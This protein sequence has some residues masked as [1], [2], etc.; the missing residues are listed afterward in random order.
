M[1]E[2][3]I[4]FGSY[5]VRPITVLDD[6]SLAATAYHSTGLQTCTSTSRRTRRSKSPT[7]MVPVLRRRD[8]RNDLTVSH[9]LFGRKEQL[10]TR[11]QVLYISPRYPQIVRCPPHYPTHSPLNSHT[12]RHPSHPHM[13]T[14]LTPSSQQPHA[15]RNHQVRPHRQHPHPHHPP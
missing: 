9:Y 1:P 2:S 14:Q 13:F 6:D 4:K 15:M 11:P 10:L 7:P 5:E 12:L 3:A 8:G